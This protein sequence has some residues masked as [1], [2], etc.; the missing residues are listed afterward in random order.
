MGILGRQRRAGAVLAALALVV[1]ACSGGDPEPAAD[2]PTPAPTATSEAAPEPDASESADVLAAGQVR[3]PGKALWFYPPVDGAMLTFTQTISGEASTLAGTV[4]AVDGGT[5]SVSED[6]GEGVIVDRRFTTTVEGG[7]VFDPDGFFASGEGFEVTAAGDSMQVPT[8]D[9]M[10][11]G[12]ATSGSTFVEFSGSGFSGR[13]DVEYTVAGGGFESVTVPAGTYDA[14]RV[15]ITLD[16]TTSQGQTFSGT[17][18]YWFVP[19][20]AVVKSTLDVGQLVTVELTG[21]TV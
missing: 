15:D 10:E 12:T 3:D 2:D 7:T 20:F 13:N 8:I 18:S 16:I 1:T 5:V 4:T 21:S 11:A 17:G 6:V 19:G 9:V 14:Y